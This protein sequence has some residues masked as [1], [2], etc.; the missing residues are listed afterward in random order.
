VLSD[1]HRGPEC[2]QQRAG[3]SLAR[4]SGWLKR[5]MD[6]TAWRVHHGSRKDRIPCHFTSIHAASFSPFRHYPLFLPPKFPAPSPRTYSLFPFFQSPTVTMTHIAS[7]SQVL[8][9]QR[10]FCSHHELR[11]Y[12]STILTPSTSLRIYYYFLLTFSFSCCLPSRL[13]LGMV[14]HS[15]LG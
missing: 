4:R 5:R 14:T 15:G 9:S 1:S 11:G 7:Y 3:V 8:F 10:C 13:V 12:P 2:C 6:V